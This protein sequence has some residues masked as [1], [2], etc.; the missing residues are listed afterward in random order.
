M[1]DFEVDKLYLPTG[2]SCFILTLNPG[3]A[4]KK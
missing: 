4:N 2:C 1:H 3:D